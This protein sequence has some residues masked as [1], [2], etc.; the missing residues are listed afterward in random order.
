MPSRF[1]AASLENVVKITSLLLWVPH[2][3]GLVYNSIDA[4][5]SAQLSTVA[6]GAVVFAS[7]VVAAQKANGEMLM[8]VMFFTGLAS[9]LLSM[10]ATESHNYVVPRNGWVVISGIQGLIAGIL[11]K[12]KDMIDG[13]YFEYHTIAERLYLV[14]PFTVGIWSAYIFLM[15]FSGFMQVISSVFFCLALV[16]YGVIAWRI[17][18]WSGVLDM[19]LIQVVNHIFTTS[20]GVVFIGFVLTFVCVSYLAVPFVQSLLQLNGVLSSM[21]ILVEMLVYD[22]A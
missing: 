3:A 21:G 6:F 17:C 9:E 22:N 20:F 7:T 19:D 8:L 13:R 15:G 10:G 18:A 12:A 4:P 2:I 11:C 14:T 5:F 16:G 1:D